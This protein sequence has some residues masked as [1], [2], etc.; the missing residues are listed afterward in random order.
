VERYDTMASI[1][2]RP[3]VAADEAHGVTELVFG[4]SYRPVPQVAFKT[5]FLLQ[6]PDGPTPSQGR[7]DLGVGVMF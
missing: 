5:D 4:V 1:K 6:N 3:E 2:G 7:F